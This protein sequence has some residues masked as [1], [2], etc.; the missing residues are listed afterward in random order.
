[1]RGRA[2]GQIFWRMLLEGKGNLNKEGA[3]AA[4]GKKKRREISQSGVPWAEE[5]DLPE[6]HFHPP[7]SR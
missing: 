2:R 7:L 5:G 6:T 3:W 1:M 4:L